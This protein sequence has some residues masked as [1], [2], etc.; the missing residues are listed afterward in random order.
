MTFTGAGSIGLSLVS[1][2]QKALGIE[3]VLEAVAS[4]KINRGLALS[5]GE[6]DCEFIC[7]DVLKPDFAAG[8]CCRQ[9]SGAD[10][11]VVDP[12]RAGLNPGVIRKIADLAPSDIAYISC[13]PATLARDLKQLSAKYVITCIT[14]VDMFRIQAA[15]RR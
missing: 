6:Q 2:G 9:D 10:A 8:D 3:V 11:L 14:P 7:R 15:S 4:A 1:P 13:D 12:P 5:G